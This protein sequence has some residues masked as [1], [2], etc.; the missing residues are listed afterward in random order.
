MN[1]HQKDANLKH[2]PDTS[3]NCDSIDIYEGYEYQ[4]C[5]IVYQ[6]QI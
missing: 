3:L 5:V 2:K 4:I 1:I 6:P